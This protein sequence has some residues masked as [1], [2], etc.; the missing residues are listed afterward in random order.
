MVAA[1]F[2]FERMK[3]CGVCMKGVVG[4]SSA[5][6]SQ[7]GLRFRLPHSLAMCSHTCLS[8]LICYKG[9][10]LE[11]PHGVLVKTKQMAGGR[12]LKQVGT[13]SMSAIIM[14]FLVQARPRGVT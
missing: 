2:Y 5:G 14:V 9:L 8:F 11:L 10:S 13:R 6:A 12:A 4:D 3:K 7:L 1:K